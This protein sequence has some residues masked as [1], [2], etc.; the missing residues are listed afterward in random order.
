[1]RVQHA[2]LSLL[3]L[4][5]LGCEQPLP[6]G[7]ADQP[8]ASAGAAVLA[9]TNGGGVIAFGVPELGPAHFAFSA[10]QNADGSVAGQFHQFR[11]R[12]GLTVDFTGEVTCVSF[13]PVK[14][15]AWIGGV[16]KR[17]DSTDPAFQV[18]TLH[19]PG[20]DVWFRVVDYSQEEVVQPDRSTTY[21]FKWSADFITSADYCAGQPWPEDDARTLPVVSGN[22]Q[23]RSRG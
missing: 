10:V 11:T 2:W 16:I 21:G 14:H 23:V 20:L 3:V 7:T 22:I 8:A 13:D 17:N 9:S 19:A 1:V 18:D 12:N 6:S 4:S 5:S 15:R